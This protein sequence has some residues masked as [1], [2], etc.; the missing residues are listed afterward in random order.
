MRYFIFKYVAFAWFYGICF[1]YIINLHKLTSLDRSI[2]DELVKL[3]SLYS[4]SKSIVLMF[5]T[6]CLPTRIT[7]LGK[8]YKLS[9]KH[10]YS[11]KIKTIFLKM[12]NVLEW[13]IDIFYRIRLNL[14][15]SKT[16]SR[17]SG[18]CSPFINFLL[19]MIYWH[20]SLWK[21]KF[22]NNG[23]KNYSKE[24]ISEGDM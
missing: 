12:Y 20:Y 16:Q 2:V 8:L 1:N 13:L 15:L 9:M 14:T 6:S 22:N 7:W 3:T 24:S 4:W 17:P 23:Y 18:F 19:E 11:R 5:K 21:Y 10:L